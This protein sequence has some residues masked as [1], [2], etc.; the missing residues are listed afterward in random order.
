MHW[1]GFFGNLS[2]TFMAEKKTK[3]ETKKK[4]ETPKKSGGSSKVKTDSKTKTAPKKK[5]DKKEAN[6]D[7][8]AVIETGSKQYCVS[9]GDIVKVEKLDIE[10]GKKVTFDKVLLVDDGLNTTIGNPYI[11]K[12]EVTGV[13][14]EVG[15][16]KKIDVVKY[17]SK[18]RYHK[19][20]GHRQHFT[21]VEIEKIK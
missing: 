19:R 12:A 1:R 9:E 18:S 10:E 6:K 21:K 17:K 20:Y 15:R 13:V 8:F 7:L 2:T 4:T 11:E 3:T 5:A 14:K 16:D